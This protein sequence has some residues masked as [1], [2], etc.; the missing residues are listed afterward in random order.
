MRILKTFKKAN[1]EQ[2]DV[3][4]T[5]PASHDK[6]SLTLR[7]INFLLEDGST[8]HLVTNLMPE[9]LK[10]EKFPELYRLRWGS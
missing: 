7:S 9:Q 1:S 4:F 8:E 6:E 5:Y 2:E 3:L 10:S